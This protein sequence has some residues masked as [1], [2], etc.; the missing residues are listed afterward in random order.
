[1]FAPSKTSFMDKFKKKGADEENPIARW[2]RQRDRSC[3]ICKRFNDTYSRYLD[4]FFH[5]YKEGTLYNMIEKSKGFCIHHFGELCS[6]AD[7]KLNGKQ[8]EEFYSLLFNVMQGAMERVGEDVSWLVEKF[9]YKNSDADWKN[10]KDA[11]QRG[12]Q[13]LRGGYPADSPHK[14]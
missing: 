3:Y 4:T 12:M 10:S 8:R 9:D 13:K 2:A 1:M 6:M 5:M 11:I 14:K 7:T